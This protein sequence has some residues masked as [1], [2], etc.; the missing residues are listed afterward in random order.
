MALLVGCSRENPWFHL[1]DDDAPSTTLDPG[2]SESTGVAAS[3]APDDTSAASTGPADT[4]ETGSTTSLSDGDTE[5]VIMTDTD[6]TTGGADTDPGTTSAAD[7]TGD[8]TTGPMETDGGDPT[9][10]DVWHD[11]LVLCPWFET[12]WLAGGD[13]PGSFECDWDWDKPEQWAGLQLE[14]AFYMGQWAQPVLALVPAVGPDNIITGTYNGL[15]LP[16]AINPHLRTIVLCPHDLPC[17]IKGNIR[18]EQGGASIVGVEDFF[19]TTGGS[20]IIDIPLAL[21]PELLGEDEFSVLVVITSMTEEPGNHGLWIYPRIVEV[22][23]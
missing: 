16:D 15:T 1:A 11:L 14:G 12:E 6:A 7:T 3:T 8:G 18:V 2:D 23:G 21:H 17:S 9:E 10:G 20:K 4:G 5:G 22:N 19:L 13:I